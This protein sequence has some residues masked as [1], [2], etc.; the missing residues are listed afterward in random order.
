ME[1]PS[2]HQ[3]PD[4]EPLY[5]CLLCRCA[6]RAAS[7]DSWQ[8]CEICGQL[9]TFE[10]IREDVELTLNWLE[11][12]LLAEWSSRYVSTARLGEDA[13]VALH[14]ILDRIRA[15]RPA[16]APALLLAERYQEEGP[17]TLEL[18]LGEEA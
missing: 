14:S 18:D 13:Q 4:Q 5:R 10:K 1:D 3:P 9:G 15:R 17:P 11:L 6:F 12:Q 2:L 7:A 16:G 8:V